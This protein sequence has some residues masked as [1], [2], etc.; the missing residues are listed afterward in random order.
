MFSGSP[1]LW[2]ILLILIF[3]SSLPGCKDDNSVSSPEP[4][5]G[6]DP[7]ESS[8]ILPQLAIDLQGQAIRDEPKVPALLTVYEEGFVRFDGHIGIEYRGATSQDLFLKKSYGIETWDENQDDVDVELLWFP[9]E[10]DWILFGP[11]SDKTLIRNAFTMRLARDMGHYASRT[12]FAEVYLDDDYLGV[13]VFMEEIKNDDVRL[14]LS[15]LDPDVNGP[16]EITGGYILKIDK[17]AGDPVDGDAT[18]TEFLGFRSQYD[19]RGNIIQYQPYGQKQSEETYFL[20][21][22]PA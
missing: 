19:V 7:S 9:E 21:E 2:G 5:P 3:T 18:Y 8:S 11:Y 17:T 16:E 14:D 1:F 22:E 4:D 13:Y 6:P 10:E 15:G 20:Y 12:R